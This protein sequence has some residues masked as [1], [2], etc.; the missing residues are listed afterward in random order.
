M[1]ATLKIDG[2]T[3]DRAVALAV[4]SAKT[5]N[6]N[7]HNAAM[8]C[9]EFSFERSGAGLDKMSSMFDK[10]FDGGAKQHMA[11]LVKWVETYFSNVS[12]S[13]SEKSGYR[14]GLASSFA[15]ETWK[16]EEARA[17]PFY[18][19]AGTN[20][21]GVQKFTLEGLLKNIRK[22]SKARQTAA[23]G[24]RDVELDAPE[25][26]YE[27]VEAALANV[28]KDLEQVIASRKPVEEQAS[29]VETF[30][31]GASNLSDAQIAAAMAKL[32]EQL[33]ARGAVQDVRQ[34][35]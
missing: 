27:R 29:E 24:K 4:K 1:S 10:L 5:A 8:L 23:N 9:V 21:D 17:N 3:V 15:P 2:A 33:V 12:V 26:I 30:V 13:R 20:D 35:A 16:L 11:K 14:I 34:A 31:D 19:L 22:L 25:L 28:A 7:I 18:S 6:V 32:Q